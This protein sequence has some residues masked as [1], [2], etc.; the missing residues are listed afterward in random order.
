MFVCSVNKVYSLLDEFGSLNGTLDMFCS[1][2]HALTEQATCV[3]STTSLGLPEC[4][5]GRHTQTW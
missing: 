5:Q 2:V 3:N 4:Q 1:T